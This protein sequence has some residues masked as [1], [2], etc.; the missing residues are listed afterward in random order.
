MFVHLDVIKN[1]T[2]F[3]LRHIDREYKLCRLLPIL[4]TS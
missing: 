2:P 4:S 1:C 3:K